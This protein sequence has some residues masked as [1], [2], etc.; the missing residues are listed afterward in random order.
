MDNIILLS[1][2]W[3]SATGAA[4]KQVEKN[5][6]ARTELWEISGSLC[7]LSTVV[8]ADLTLFSF[9]LLKSDVK[10]WRTTMFS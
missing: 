7:T 3:A 2:V 6:S 9:A 5:M 10:P 8:G 1:S 4:A